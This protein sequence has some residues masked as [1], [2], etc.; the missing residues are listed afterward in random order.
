[1]QRLLMCR[2]VLV[3]AVMMA[4][5]G[6]TAGSALGKPVTLVRDGQAVMT[7]LSG[8]VD[9]PRSIERNAEW[10]R[11]IFHPVERL[12]DILA[13]ISGAQVTIQPAS[14]GAQGVYVGLVSDFPWLKLQGTENLG[15]EGFIIRSDGASLYLIAQ[16]PLGV[17]HAVSTFLFQLGCR[18]FFPGET[19]TVIP[20]MATIEGSWDL[21]QRP[22]FHSFR[23]MS[24]GSG[25]NPPQQDEGFLW[26]AMN[27]WGG[28][29]HMRTGHTW[30][31]IDPQ[32]DF[33]L[34]PEWGALVTRDGVTERRRN[35][36]CYSHPQVLDRIIE[37]ARGRAQRGEL[38]I[39][40]SP[41]DGLGYCECERCFAVFE[42]GTP[43]EIHRVW[44]ATR[45]DGTLVNVTSETLFRMINTVAEALEQ[46]FPH[47]LIASHAYSAYSHPPTF[48]L[49]PNVYV[50]VATSFHRSPMSLEQILALWRQRTSRMGIYDYWSVYQWDWDNPDPGHTRDSFDPEVQSLFTDP[51]EL[52]PHRLQRNIQLYHASGATTLRTETSNNWGA[53]GLSYYIGSQL[54]WDVHADVNELI[55]D[56]YQKAFGPAAEPMQRYY[57]LWYGPEVVVLPGTSPTRGPQRPLWNRDDPSGSRQ[58][59]EQAMLHLDAAER[60]VINAPAYRDRIDHLRMY[61]LAMYLRLREWEATQ[62]GDPQQ[63]LDAIRDELTFSGRLIATNMVHTRALLNKR[64]NR[65]YRQHEQLWQDLPEMQ[66]KA[67]WRK[68]GTTPSRDEVNE[69]WAQARTHLAQPFTAA[70]RVAPSGRVEMVDIETD[71]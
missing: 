69:L 28:P 4:A 14:A 49:H 70:Q 33:D 36:P 67:G 32:K 30:Y 58:T 22:D 38:R 45:P 27:R 12:R 6:L 26:R 18:W 11:P 40:L 43:T 19:W 59:L 1:M 15:A 3:L 54:L 16:E 39:S 21:R 50:N 51:A 29:E 34:N 20:R 41:P 35:K 46:D 37:H 17:Q 66:G 25:L 31:G 9:G 71:D 63:I 44:Y 57:E 48:K 5:I 23:H 47:V 60:L 10:N 68:V 7:I 64:Y 62:I 61:M 42:G 2:C 52:R 8:S 65:L 24:T 13:Q 55:R 53:R 56:F